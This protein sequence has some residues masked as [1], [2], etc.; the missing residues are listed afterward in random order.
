M[1]DA[2]IRPGAQDATRWGL[3]V[4]TGMM[5][6]DYTTL[7]ELHRHAAAEGELDAARLLTEATA[8]DPMVF[9]RSQ[10]TA[11]KWCL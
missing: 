6:V 4:G 1:R 5:G 9:C 7:A 3:S 2:G 11:G 8:R 10:S